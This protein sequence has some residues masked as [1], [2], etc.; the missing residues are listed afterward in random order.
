M[1]HGT[2]GDREQEIIDG[3]KVICKCRNIRKS[4]FLK[5]I[6]AGVATVEALKKATGAGTGTCKGK[7]CTGKIEEL[8]RKKK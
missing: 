8:L 3:L 7:E 6:R 1:E 5:H 4:V 2:T